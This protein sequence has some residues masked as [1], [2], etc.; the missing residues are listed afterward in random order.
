MT[1]DIRKAAALACAAAIALPATSALAENDPIIQSDAAKLRKLEVML[2][3]T[4]L[5]CRGGAHD[6]RG[7]YNRFSVIHSERLNTARANLK[8]GLAARYG[9]QGS[10]R[11]L[12]R[13]GVKMANTYGSGHPWMGCAELKSEVQA[14][15]SVAERTELLSAASRLLAPARPQAIEVAEAVPTTQVARIPYAMSQ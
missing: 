10:K 3:V 9:G 6:F 11:A 2:M 5:R 4:S 7:D 12:D 1:K 15:G 8:R 13:L 14:L